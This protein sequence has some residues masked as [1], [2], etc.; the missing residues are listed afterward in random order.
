MKESDHLIHSEEAQAQ[1]RKNL[2]KIIYAGSCVI[3]PESAMSPGPQMEA[4]GIRGMAPSLTN[5]P[6]WIL[7]GKLSPRQP[8]AQGCFLAMPESLNISYSKYVLN[9]N[10]RCLKK[11]KKNRED[12]H[13]LGVTSPGLCP[14]KAGQE[15]NGFDL[16]AV[17]AEGS[18]NNKEQL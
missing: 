8:S 7:K 17:I 15:S 9:P 12:D 4:S 10:E 14:Q 6:E 16:Q 11:K 1:V 2:F 3:D 18:P 13:Q 5:P